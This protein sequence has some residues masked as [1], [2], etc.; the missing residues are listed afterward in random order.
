MDY[1]IPK[2]RTDVNACD[3]TWECTD[4]VRESAPKIDFGR[5][6]PCAPGNRICSGGSQFCLS[7]P[8]TRRP[9]A[10]SPLKNKKQNL[11]QVWHMY[12]TTFFLRS[13]CLLQ[14]LK[15]IESTENAVEVWF[16]LFIQALKSK[17]HLLRE[18]DVKVMPFHLWMQ[19]NSEWMNHQWSVISQSNNQSVGHL[20][21]TVY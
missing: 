12:S 4:T 16:C 2:V 11:H 5:K 15:V 8:V 20:C 9:V 3:Y 10:R 6:I 13:T 21:T 18:T 14:K 17:K 1:R 19:H 7:N